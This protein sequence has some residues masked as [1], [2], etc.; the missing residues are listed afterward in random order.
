MRECWCGHDQAH[1]RNLSQKCT[2]DGCRCAGFYDSQS[3]NEDEERSRRGYDD[4]P[5]PKE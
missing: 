3:Y 4:P 5:K 1:H 2:R